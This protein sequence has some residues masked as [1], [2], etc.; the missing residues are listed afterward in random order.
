MRILIAFVAASS[1]LFAT[2]SAQKELASTA[3][4]LVPVAEESPG[5]Y[6][7]RGNVHR[8]IVPAGHALARS[9]RAGQLRAVSE[10]YGSFEVLEVTVSSPAELAALLAR[11]A[12]LADHMNL[13]ELNG[14]VLDGADAEATQARRAE[15]PSLLRTDPAAE[16]RLELVQFRGRSRTPGARASSRPA[17]SW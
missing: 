12:T 3:H 6:V 16:R 4:E 9:A 17:P 14:F 1:F 5:T 11:G 2:T 7:A 15:I 13:V 10:D 8:L